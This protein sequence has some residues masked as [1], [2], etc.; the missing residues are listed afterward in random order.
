MIVGTAK[1]LGKTSNNLVVKY[2]DSAVSK[3]KM[4]KHLGVLIDN[5]LN[6]VSILINPIHVLAPDCD[7]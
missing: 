7:C 1:R 4:Y 2:R 6:L 5:T 3:V